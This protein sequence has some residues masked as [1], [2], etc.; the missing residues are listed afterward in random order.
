MN[1][2]FKDID[3]LAA[4]FSN[5]VVD[6]NDF[7]F[8]K[9]IGQGGFSKVYF[10]IQKSTKRMCAI[11]LLNFKDL[12]KNRFLAYERE[13][14]VLAAVKNPFLLSFVGFSTKYPFAIITDYVRNGSLFDAVRV[15][16]GDNALSG[17]DKTKIAL[18][19]AHGMKRLHELG[20]IHR[21]L[22]S[23]NILLDKSNI[24]KIADFGLSRYTPD[25]PKQLMTGNVGTSHWMAPEILKNAHYDN[26]ADVYS[27]GILLW[28]ILTGKTPFS[29]K[30]PVQI[31]L[32]VLKKQ[33][34]P[35]IPKKTPGP[36]KELISAC[37]SQHPSKRP[38]FDDIFHDFSKHKVKFQNTDD[39]AIDELCR[40]IRHSK[41]EII[42]K[43]DNE[44]PD[45]LLSDESPDFSGD[46]KPEDVIDSLPDPSSLHYEAEMIDYI[47]TINED[48][49]GAFFE[50]IAGVI[51]LTQPSHLISTGLKVILILLKKKEVYLNEFLSQNLHLIP[52]YEMSTI[53]DEILEF[54]LYLFVNSP[55]SISTEILSGIQR[56]ALEAPMKYIRFMNIYTCYRPQ[57]P[58]FFDAIDAL[59]QQS[60]ILINNGAGY[61]LLELIG[62][63]IQ[64]S[65]I[66][67][68]YGN[69]IKTI[70]QILLSSKDLKS[71][72]LIF[73]MMCADP[74]L[75]FMV[76]ADE[77]SKYLMLPS[78]NMVTLSL[79]PRLTQLVPT[80]GLITALL[81]NAQAH[82]IAGYLLLRFC[83]TPSSAAYVAS[84]A[85]S[86]VNVP[87]PTYKMT[88]KLVFMILQFDDAKRY[89]LSF[90]QFYD[91]IINLLQ[92][93]NSKY[94][95]SITTIF[96]A[97]PLSVSI[98]SFLS[99]SHFLRKFY[100][101]SIQK[102]TH[103]IVTQCLFLTDM[104]AR[105]AYIPDYLLL[106]PS[107]RVL[108]SDSNYRML[109]L[110]LLTTLS[111]YDEPKEI[112]KKGNY[113]ELVKQF[114]NV[115]GLSQYAK[116]FL[117]Q[118]S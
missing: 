2:K 4:H 29:G 8:G 51:Q 14:L 22:K 71:I 116:C 101:I 26:K 25:T 44:L 88:A 112:F 102:N 91:F 84:Q 60:Q 111:L 97:L 31:A 115:D 57:L 42:A 48:N 32:A 103:Q 3:E 83:Q 9:K 117:T 47:E 50:N 5:F 28:E 54:Y 114:Q 96:Q 6:I 12:K 49:I 39:K 92:I 52:F 65:E 23:L 73:H 18:G 67:Q 98:I 106:L 37:W 63:I 45:D 15:R 89:V 43:L 99:S 77:L 53:S 62:T 27:Y 90:P 105:I 93:D 94:S 30:S 109:A 85:S 74:N 72:E 61:Q 110:S 55:K 58:Y 17:T 86:W 118:I 56:L 107:L 59:F 75:L 76:S 87:L 21:D 13:I 95:C 10:A 24:P 20:I 80:T 79:I 69:A 78:I 16:R 70:M 40:Q 113:F 7:K 35:K 41:I 34:R 33:E 36:L 1:H 19:I 66:S 104:F 108:I 46:G 81:C 64:L 82:K 38:T 11:K 100:E 68:S